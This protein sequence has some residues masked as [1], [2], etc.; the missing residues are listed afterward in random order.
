MEDN[1]EHC[2]WGFKDGEGEAK[3]QE[4][5]EQQWSAGHLLKTEGWDIE[6]G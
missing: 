4:I 3:D 1:L 2:R 5:G 6:K